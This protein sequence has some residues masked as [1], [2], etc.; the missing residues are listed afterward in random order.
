MKRVS[1]EYLDGLPVER[2]R[3]P[4]W[5][6]ED[7]G[8]VGLAA[9]FARGLQGQPDFGVSCQVNLWARTGS[10]PAGRQAVASPRATAWA[11]VHHG[12]PEGCGGRGCRPARCRPGGCRPADALLAHRAHRS[13][14]HFQ[15]AIGGQ[16][17]WH[18]ATPI[19]S[20]SGG[21]IGSSTSVSHEMNTKGC[22]RCSRQASG[23]RPSPSP[24]LERVDL[25]EHEG[26]V[27]IGQRHELA[28]QVPQAQCD[29]EPVS[30]ANCST[31]WHRIGRWATPTSD[32]LTY[33]VNP[34]SREPVPAVG[35]HPQRHCRCPLV[36]VHQAHH[37][38]HLGRA[39]LGVDAVFHRL[40]AVHHARH[41]GDRFTG[42]VDARIQLLRLRAAVDAQLAA[43]ARRSFRA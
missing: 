19:Q 32:L 10:R 6:F 20:W 14:G 22:C 41:D 17:V 30:G 36:I 23:L 11:A 43:G 12:L 37:V 3:W 28:H 7:G 4:R 24:G 9:Q 16:V 38:V 5:P 39:G 25:A 8:A 26:A 40:H 18:P 42:A 34:P 1:S 31:M 27:G 13:V 29:H 35:M 15:R 2:T 33:F 21:G